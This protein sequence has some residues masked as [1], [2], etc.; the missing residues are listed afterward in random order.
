MFTWWGIYD[1]DDDDHDDDEWW[2]WMLI[3]D[4]DNAVK[5]ER[6][7]QQWCDEEWWLW[8]RWCMMQDDAW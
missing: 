5:D 7:C 3:N 1:D 2:W 4:V 6:Q 8:G